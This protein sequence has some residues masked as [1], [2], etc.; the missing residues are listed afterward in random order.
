MRRSTGDC[1]ATALV[2]CRPGRGRGPVVR[3][4]PLA[5]PAGEGGGPRGGGDLSGGSSRGGRTRSESWSRPS[6]DGEKLGS[7]APSRRACACER[8]RPSPSWPRRWR[9]RSGNPLNLISLSV[10]HIGT[11][12]QPPTRE[13]RRS[14]PDHR[15]VR[16]ELLA[17]QPQMVSDFL[18]YGRPPRLA[19]RT[20]RVDE[21]LDEVLSLVQAKARDQRIGSS[22]RPVGSSRSPGG[23]GRSEDLFPERG[24]QCPAGHAPGGRLTTEARVSAEPYGRHGGV[25]SRFQ[26]HTAAASPSPTSSASSSLTSRRAR[27]GG[28]GGARDPP[29]RI[30]QDH[31]GE[32]RVDSAPDGGTTFRIDLP[33]RG[34]DE[35]AS[36]DAA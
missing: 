23:R 9:T 28:A 24:D 30:V 35:A 31:G 32:I 15:S 17:P 16:D 14:T 6:T 21:T 10:D 22:A 7:S 5:R 4:D 29:Q 8:A 11:E 18:S 34:P 13:R 12:F 33:L 27:P 25:D 1:F 19:L 26:R 3:R 36:R 20:C 2:S